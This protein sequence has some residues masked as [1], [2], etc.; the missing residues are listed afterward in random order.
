MQSIEQQANPDVFVMIAGLKRDLEENRQVTYREGK[1]FAENIGDNA[2]FC[3][4]SALSG[5]NVN[6][7]FNT[8][9]VS[10]LKLIKDKAGIQ[11][12]N[13]RNNRQNANINVNNDDDSW[14]NFATS[15][16]CC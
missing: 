14:W 3:E 1:Q 4:V 16:S 12:Y 11:S 13:H 5:F 10:T 6:G 9:A 8:V 2:R 7:L 15:A